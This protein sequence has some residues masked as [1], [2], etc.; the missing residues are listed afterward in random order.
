MGWLRAGWNGCV[1]AL[2]LLTGGLVAYEVGCV[3][4]DHRQASYPARSED[5][6]GC[7]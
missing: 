7:R 6:D 3:G 2:T 5:D 4:W 1:V